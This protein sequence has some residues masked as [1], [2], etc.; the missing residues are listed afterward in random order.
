MSI[1]LN[2]NDNI[3]DWNDEEHYCKILGVSWINFKITYLWYKKLIELGY[4][5][6][7]ITIIDMDD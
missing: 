6:D 7:F 3:N 4:K 2:L 1:K 5:N